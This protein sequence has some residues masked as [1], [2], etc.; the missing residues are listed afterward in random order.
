[1][2]PAKVAQALKS[3]GYKDQN[4]TGCE[5]LKRSAAGRVVQIEVAGPTSRVSSDGYSFRQFL[6][7][8]GVTSTGYREGE[9]CP[10]IPPAR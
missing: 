6:G 10:R 3:V 4:V 2:L 1:M 5:V 8:R 9:P 7:Y